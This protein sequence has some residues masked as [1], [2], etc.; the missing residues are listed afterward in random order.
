MPALA[1]APGAAAPVVA[2]AVAAGGTAS[3]PARDGAVLL[4]PILVNR[5]APTPT[6][7][8][9]PPAVTESVHEKGVSSWSDAAQFEGS[10]FTA[11]DVTGWKPYGKFCRNTISKVWRVTPPIGF[12]GS[13][14]SATDHISVAFSDVPQE[15]RKLI[16]RTL[17]PAK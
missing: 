13:T 11:R 6:C 17:R 3:A 8:M 12:R 4:Y 16:S 15:V 5:C 14:C 9:P 2:A 1:V 10:G 7:G